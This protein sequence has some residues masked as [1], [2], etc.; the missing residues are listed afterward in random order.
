MTRNI[1]NGD[2]RGYR[3]KQLWYFVH[4]VVTLL[5]YLR[6]FFV[7]FGN[8]SCPKQGSLSD[9]C[10]G[11]DLVAKPCDPGSNTALGMLDSHLVTKSDTCVSY[12]FLQNENHTNATIGANENDVLK[13]HLSFRNRCKINKFKHTRF[14]KCGTL[15]YMNNDVN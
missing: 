15:C 5:L 6:T 7:F 12:S 2:C 13:L 4:S 14:L 1:C 11:N 10:S 3:Y 8:R 9:W